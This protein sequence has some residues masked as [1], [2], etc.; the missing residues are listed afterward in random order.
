VL[1]IR[2]FSEACYQIFSGCLPWHDSKSGDI[3]NALRQRCMPSRP[4]GG[5]IDDMLW[6]FITRCCS[7]TPSERPSA[8]QIL[9]F[10]EHQYKP[11]NVDISPDN[12]TELLDDVPSTPTVFGGFA[13]IRKCTLKR[14]GK[15]I[16]V[17]QISIK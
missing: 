1:A 8:T 6:N 17:G 3:I 13:D 14:D 9:D 5:G 12:L 16:Q 7:F 10:F 11:S 2:E 4:G 15:T